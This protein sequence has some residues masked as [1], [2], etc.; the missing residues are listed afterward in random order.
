MQAII[1][2]YLP[3]TNRLPSRIKASCERGS[4]TRS[5]PHDLS[6]DSCHAFVANLLCE[7][8]VAED[9]K[10]YGSRPETN[11][12]AGVRIM[13]TIPSGEVVHVFSPVATAARA[14][15]ESNTTSNRANLRAALQS[16]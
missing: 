5:Y 15:M 8:F 2:K 13:G 10:A 4:I 11:P 16:S 3:A 7:R 12:W 1:S 9:A 6:G 14:Y